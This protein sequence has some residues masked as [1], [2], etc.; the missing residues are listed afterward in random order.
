MSHEN[1]SAH[2]IDGLRI[3]YLPISALRPAERNARK[4]TDSDVQAIVRSIQEFGFSDPIG[5][6]GGGE[7][8]CGGTRAAIS[9]AE[10]RHD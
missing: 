2:V 10:A 9:G 4:H 3:E 5:I 6:W 1:G 8:Y 7:H